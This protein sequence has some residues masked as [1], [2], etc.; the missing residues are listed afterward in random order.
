MIRANLPAT[1]IHAGKRAT[2]HVM[3]HV[4]THATHVS[5]HASPR[6]LIPAGIHVN[7]HASGRHAGTRVKGIP[8]GE[9]VITRAGKPVIHAWIRVSTPVIHAGTHV[10]HA[11]VH[12][13]LVGTRA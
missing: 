12:V 9:P 5:T 10:L 3:T 13:R 11:R 2:P 1:L 6:V 4:G 8:A 7:P